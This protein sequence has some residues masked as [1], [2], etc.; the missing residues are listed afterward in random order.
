MFVTM[1]QPAAHRKRDQLDWPIKHLASQRG[2]GCIAVQSLMGPP[3]MVVVL[4][5]P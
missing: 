4:Y 5:V 1:V 2:N 3:D